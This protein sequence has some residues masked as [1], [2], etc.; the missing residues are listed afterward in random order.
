MFK[1][2]KGDTLI[3]LIVATAILVMVLSSIFI[4]PNFI[5]ISGQENADRLSA[6]AKIL[7]VKETMRAEWASAGM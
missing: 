6:L 2:R 4:L 5:R 7:A 3:E 1:N